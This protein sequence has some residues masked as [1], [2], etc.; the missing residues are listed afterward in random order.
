[1]TLGVAY[2]LIDQDPLINGQQCQLDAALMK[3]LGANT[4][5]VYHVDASADHAACMNVFAAVGIYVFVDLDSFKTYIGLVGT[6][7]V[8]LSALTIRGYF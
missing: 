8:F 5:R 6:K 4:I 1:M 2:Q 3:T 7:F